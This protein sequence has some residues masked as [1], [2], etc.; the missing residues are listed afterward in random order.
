MMIDK[1]AFFKNTMAHGKY[2]YDYNCILAS[3][4]IFGIK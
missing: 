4:S 3:E 2:N 1:K